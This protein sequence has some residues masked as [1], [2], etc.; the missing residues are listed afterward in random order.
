MIDTTRLLSFRINAPPEAKII[1]PKF[2]G[3]NEA[4]SPYSGHNFAFGGAL[5]AP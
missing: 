1:S 3:Q 4:N 2:L 5:E